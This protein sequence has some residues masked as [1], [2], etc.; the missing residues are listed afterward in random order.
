MKNGDG[1]ATYT[2]NDYQTIL[3]EAA[4]IEAKYG[5]YFD[6]VL[7]MTDNER[8]YQE[9]RNEINAL[10]QEP[11][12]IPSVWVKWLPNQSTRA[13]KDWLPN[14]QTFCSMCSS[15]EDIVCHL[16]RHL[17]TEKKINCL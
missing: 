11:Q 2:L 12:W 13:I 6:M 17:Q 4:E 5:H 3:D 10:E 7:Q 9:L 8:A 14:K 16:Y 1:S 15:E